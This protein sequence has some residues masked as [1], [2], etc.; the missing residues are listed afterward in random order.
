MKI[1]YPCSNLTVGC[2]AARKFRL[3]SYTP[4]RLVATV[5]FNIDCLQRILQWNLEHDIRY[6]RISS[7]TIPFASHSV[8]TFDWQRHFA[9]QFAHLGA[10]IQRHGMRINVHTGQYILL[11][12]P[13][14]D[15]VERSIAE[16]VY[17]AEL[18][19]LMGLDHTHKM[20]IHTGGVYGD[21]PAAMERFIARYRELPGLV[22]KRLVIENDERQ[23]GLADNLTIH[24]E[25]GVPLLFDTFHHAIFNHGE[26]LSEAFDLFM[27]TW[28]SHGVPMMDYSSQH[29]ER[30]AGAH[31]QSINMADFGKMMAQLGKRDVDI[32]LEIKDKERSALTAME[33]LPGQPGKEQRECRNPS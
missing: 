21:K 23:Y 16:L 9:E 33:W 27:P 6:F 1:G 25:T 2:S 5:Q 19:D 3:A 11:N 15:I 22:R 4:E 28:E 8:M 14:L 29:A 20:Q 13:R 30:Q 7:D 31:T 26:R 18:L 12:S 17:H 24:R 10:F 32:M